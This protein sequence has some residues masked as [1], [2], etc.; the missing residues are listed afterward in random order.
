MMMGTGRKSKF[1]LSFVCD[2][3]CVVVCCI[4]CL[5]DYL[6]ALAHSASL[7]AFCTCTCT[8]ERV[9]VYFYEIL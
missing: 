1:R 6:H 7:R 2:V 5:P 9:C 8:R 4:A 3:S